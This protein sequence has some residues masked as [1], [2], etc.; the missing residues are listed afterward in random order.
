MTSP[1][2][3]KAALFETSRTN[4]PAAQCYTSE[5]KSPQQHPCSRTSDLVL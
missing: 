3:M 1:L 5:D 4:H 2:K